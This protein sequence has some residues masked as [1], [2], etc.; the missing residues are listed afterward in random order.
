MNED[1]RSPV[2]AA[3]SLIPRQTSTSD[4]PHLTPGTIPGAGETGSTPRFRAPPGSR[5][6]QSAPTSNA[7]RNVESGGDEREGAVGRVPEA[8]GRRRRRP[9]RPWIA[10]RRRRREVSGRRWSAIPCSYKTR[11]QGGRGCGSSIDSIVLL[12][13]QDYHCAPSL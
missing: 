3:E 11:G 10:L 1:I 5:R 9:R 12:R 7:E 8:A 13:E 2:G 6:V 4:P